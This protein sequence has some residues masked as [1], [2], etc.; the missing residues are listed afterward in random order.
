MHHRIGHL[1]EKQNLF[2]DYM[3]DYV[4][5]QAPYTAHDVELVFDLSDHAA[6][7]ATISK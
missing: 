5:T 7:V 4:F 6:V 3:V 1:P 2:T